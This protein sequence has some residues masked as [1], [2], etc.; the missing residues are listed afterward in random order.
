MKII[1]LNYINSLINSK[2]IE[3]IS[4]SKVLDV[5]G[6]C[7]VPEN[8]YGVYI[9]TIDDGRQYVGKSSKGNIGIVGRLQRHTCETWHKKIIKCIDILVTKNGNQASLL[10]MILWEDLKP[11]LNSMKPGESENENLIQE[12]FKEV[13]NKKHKLLSYEEA[14]KIFGIETNKKRYVPI[15]LAKISNVKIDNEFYNILYSKNDSKNDIM[16]EEKNELRLTIEEFNLKYPYKK[17]TRE[18]LINIIE[19]HKTS[20]NGDFN[21]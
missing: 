8:L 4:I 19:E 13:S 20:I 6:V 12:T 10:E 21:E 18:H 5:R 15:P 17:V 11:E 3:I 14:D 9:I 16:I 1:D 2:N 7:T